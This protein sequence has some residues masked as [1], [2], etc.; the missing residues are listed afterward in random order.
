TTARRRRRLPSSVIWTAFS[1][2]CAPGRTSSSRR[3]MA[4]SGLLQIRDPR[5]PH[6]KP[7]G[8][9]LGTTHSLVAY[10]DREG[11]GVTIPLEGESHLLHSVVHYPEDGPADVGRAPQAKLPT[12]THTTTPSVKLFMGKGR[13]D[14]EGR[15]LGHY[16]FPPAQP[17]DA[18]VRF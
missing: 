15:R 14:P 6:G 18:V 9:D 16:R 13:N 8:I 17:G 2:T 11:K 3:N 4:E 10:V 1:R 5:K 7:V 12:P